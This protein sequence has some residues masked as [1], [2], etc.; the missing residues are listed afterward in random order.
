[1]TK[2]GK[3]TRQDESMNRIQL[4]REQTG[5]NQEQLGRK[6]GWSSTAQS[7]IS[8]YENGKRTPSLGDMRAIVCAL[9][10]AG[11]ECTIDDLFPPQANSAA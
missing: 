2:R 5:L 7:R 1:M 9:N 8:N 3:S 10:D 4:Y 6:C 11:A